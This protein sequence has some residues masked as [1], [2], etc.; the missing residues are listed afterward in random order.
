MGLSL[1]STAHQDRCKFS[2]GWEMISTPPGAC[3]KSED[4]STLITGWIP[5]TTPSTVASTLRAAGLWSFDEPIRRFD[6]EDW[7][8]RLRF[9]ASRPEAGESAVLG[10]DGLAT[11]AEDWLNGT[12]VLTSDNM[13]IAHG[14]G[15][16]QPAGR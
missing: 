8:Y 16:W 12:L 5:A 15:R 13:F 2:T 9:A 6:A 3:C 14:P 1:G 4:L 10:F 11:A 7:W